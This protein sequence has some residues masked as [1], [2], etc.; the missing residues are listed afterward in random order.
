MGEMRI[1]LDDAPTDGGFPQ[2]PDQ[3]TQ[4]QNAPAAPP[5]AATVLSGTIDERLVNLQE[6]LDAARREVAST[7]QQKKDRELTIAQLQDQ[8]RAATKPEPRETRGALERFMAG[9]A[10]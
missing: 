6:Q 9:E 2:T 10:V 8:L 5:A 3:K 7:A 4:T 1:L